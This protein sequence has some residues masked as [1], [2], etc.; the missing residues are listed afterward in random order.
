MEKYSDLSREQLVSLL[1]K[2]DREK[3]LGLVWERDALEADR[4]LEAEFITATLLPELSTDSGSWPNL[5]IE[6]DNY[7][8]LRWLR[9]TMSGRIKCIYVDPPYNTGNKDWVYNDHYV[10]PTDRWRHSTWLEFLYQRFSLAR[11]LLAEDGVL[12]VSINNDNRAKLELMLDE[13]LPGMRIG[14]F[15]WRT[16]AGTRGE[17]PFFS[18]DN[19]YVLV[20]GGRDFAFGGVATNR[21]KY[22][23]DGDGL[24]PWTSVALQTNKD[25][26]ERPGSYFPVPH[27]TNE[28]WHP[29]NPNRTWSFQLRAS[30]TARGATYEDMLESGIILFSNEDDFFF[31]DSMSDLLEC[32]RSKKTHPYLREDLP[33]LDFWVNRRIGAGTV[34]KKQFLRDLKTG[35]KSVSSWIEGNDA[36]DGD[37]EEVTIL[38]SDMTTGGTT[39][40]TKLFGRRVFNFA[41]PPSLL[42]ALVKQST[43]PG[44]FVLDFFA[45]SATTAQAVM[46]LNAEEPG[47][48]RRFIMV[49]SRE[50]TDKEPDKNLCRDITSERIRRLNGSVDPAY[51]D[52]HAEFAYLRCADI[53]FEDIDYD[54]DPA[55]CWTALET[56]H[57][58][59]LTPYET[60]RPWQLHTGETVTLVYVNGFTPDIVPMLRELAGRRASVFVYA[61][62]PGQLRDALSR[63]AGDVDIDINSVRDT[64]VRRFRQ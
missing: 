50:N 11:D 48:E 22:N 51:A 29:C 49:S 10:S 20:Y 13:V 55:T 46:D 44:D 56:L 21:S 8:A 6:G 40:I 2:A 14:S 36:L 57:G 23:D 1:L 24:G 3:K 28:N 9:M 18:Q 42:K 60:D 7:D 37:S 16:R 33:D 43:G 4:A 35:L 27:P 5:V 15:C 54:L 17:A 19:E 26:I 38:K 61:W 62:A 34:R 47:D 12:L 32:I 53:A 41:K 25:Y 52:Y 30:G 63:D 31:H 39:S 59:P 45:G 58:L 64:L